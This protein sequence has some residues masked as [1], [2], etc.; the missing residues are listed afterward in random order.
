MYCAIGVEP[1]NEIAATSGCSSSASTATLSPCTTL[2][3]PSGTPASCSSCARYT[4]RRRILL[5]RLEHERVPARDR[6]REHPHRHHRGEVER[7]DPADDAERLADRVD[8]DAGRRLLGVAALQQVRDAA[9]ELDD[10]EPARDL[11]ERVGR[12]LAVLGGEERRDVLAMLVDQLA[13]AEQDLGAPRRATSRA[14][15]GN[16]AFAAATACVDLLDGREVDRAGLPA[17]RRVVD[18]AAAAGRPGDCHPADPVVD[19]LDG[20]RRLLQRVGHDRGRV[21]RPR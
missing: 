16:A 19:R 11:A 3:T 7:R 18:R 12:H 15:R 14:T 8:V 1:T 10:L 9:R 5:R 20:G 13:D 17:G 2:N 4:R 21:P 6:R